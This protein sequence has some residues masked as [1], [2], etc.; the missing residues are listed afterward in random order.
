MLRRWNGRVAAHLVS[1]WL[2]AVSMC[3]TLVSS[4]ATGAK[5][6]AVVVM[7]VTVVVVAFSAGRRY[8]HDSVD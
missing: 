1:A 5:V 8:A 2:F 4:T 3:L 6:V 7:P